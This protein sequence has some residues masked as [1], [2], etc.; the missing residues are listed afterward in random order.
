MVSVGRADSAQRF[1]HCQTARGL[2]LNN[3]FETFVFT[4][5]LLYGPSA[6]T[7]IVALDG[8]VISFWIAKRHRELHRALFNMSAPAIS[9]WCSAQLFFYLANVR[10]LSEEAPSLERILY[11]L[12][13][14]ALVHF[15]LNSWL[16]TFIFALEK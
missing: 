5:V 9:L 8:L 6:G 16:I 10:P 2:R 12:I 15:T 13:V 1:R 14:F 4:A 11:P 3:H 7:L